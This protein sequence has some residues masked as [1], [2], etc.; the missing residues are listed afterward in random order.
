[1]ELEQRQIDEG[2]YNESAWSIFNKSQ[3]LKSIQKKF[4]QARSE[5]EEQMEQLFSQQNV[6]RMSFGSSSIDN[7]GMSEL[8]NVIMVERTNIKW[9]AEKLE[10]QVTKPIARQVIKKK[11]TIRDMRGLSRYLASCGVDQNEFKKY[12]EVEKTVDQQEVERLSELGKISV[13]NISGC[14][15]V[16][17]QKPYFR[18][19][20]KKVD[21]NDYGEE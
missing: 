9:F 15:M 17:C 10:K 18:L 12:I 1:M 14:Y 4:E 8:L 21:G 11:Y 5:F 6:K 20:V 16:E 19:S 2:P 13:K 3:K 7:D